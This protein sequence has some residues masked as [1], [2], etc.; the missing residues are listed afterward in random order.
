MKKIVILLILTI[1][2]S[3]LFASEL[4][5]SGKSTYYS[6][7]LDQGWDKGVMGS[8]LK[9][10]ATVSYGKISTTLTSK[11]SIEDRVDPAINGSVDYR[12]KG[13][14]LGTKSSSLAHID[15]QQKIDIHT[16]FN[17]VGL[18][19]KAESVILGKDSSSSYIESCYE[20]GVLKNLSIDMIVGVGNKA[21]TKSVDPK[22]KIVNT[23][24][25]GIYD[26]NKNISIFVTSVFNP[27]LHNE[28]TFNNLD[29][30]TGVIVK[31]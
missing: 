23:Q 28:F 3:I 9:T 27:V 24:I 22:F 10:S 29:F 8:F 12:I 4:G 11:Q 1:F 18:S 13:V 19:I 17:L 14:S 26:L 25:L 31:L 15:K 2:P 5:I 30:S 16:S 7:Y 6:R 21:Y 20:I